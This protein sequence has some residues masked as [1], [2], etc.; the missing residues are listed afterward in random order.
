LARP[1]VIYGSLIAPQDGRHTKVFAVTY[2]A[3]MHSCGDEGT[4]A[5]PAVSVGQALRPL[6][7]DP[8][9]RIVLEWNAKAAVLSAMSRGAIFLI[10]S[11]KSHHG[12]RAHGALV[13]AV[14]GA[15]NAGIFGTLTQAL[16]FAEPEWAAGLLVAVV[17]PVIF[18]LGDY[19][20]HAALGTQKFLAGM[21]SSA[22]FTALSALF[23][24]Y[25]MRRGTLLTGAEGR[26]FVDDLAA[27]P[28]LILMF[29]VSAALGVRRFA[30]SIFGLDASG[31]NI[32]IS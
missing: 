23:N 32:A 17:F 2:A 28:R 8:W 20:F 4:L 3:Y 1:L 21:I 12:G 13:E 25:I 22:V 5:R 29:V 31:G 10:A 27:L 15:M 18:Q 16:R 11:L 30:L 6:L 19:G 24:L 14:W 9:R 7:R 26:P